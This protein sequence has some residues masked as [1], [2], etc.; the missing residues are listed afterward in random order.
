MT[1]YDRYI[2][3][4]TEQVYQ[5]MLALGKEAFSSDNQSDIDQVLTELF[6]RVAYNLNI[7]Y[8]EL[9]SINYL[10]K[11]E[12]KYNFERPLH[13][14]LPETR[15]LL[16]R[17]DKAVKPYGFVPLSLKYFYNLVGGVNFAWDYDTNEDFM[18]QLADPIQ[19]ASLDAIV[20]TVTG[21]YWHEEMRQIVDEGELP[22]LELS[23]DDLHKD[24]VS[25]GPP[26]SLEI[27]T[28]PSVDGLFLNEPNNT[29]FINYFRICIDN[30]GF[31]SIRRSD[32]DNDYQ[33]FFGKVKPL[34]K[35][36]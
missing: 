35:P 10:F 34:L 3:G 15:V 12:F 5:H 28:D 24:N 4:Q 18:W 6:S 19:I 25:G 17:L 30:C 2:S 33:A 22:C 13:K 31:P 29:T 36:I 11:T 7:I 27:T 1:L 16:D 9:N 21:K 32:C 8:S 23:A 26:Y 14:P 20:D